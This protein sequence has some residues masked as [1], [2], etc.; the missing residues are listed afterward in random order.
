MSTVERRKQGGYRV[1]AN[2]ERISDWLGTV[3][4]GVGL[5]QLTVLPGRLM[6][7]AEFVGKGLGS[8][9]DATVA[10]PAA[11]VAAGAII[12]YY[13]V[14]GFLLGYL[15]TRL[16]LPLALHEAEAHEA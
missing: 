10:A 16:T 7:L 15:W 5:T 12:V 6:L 1:N 13:G 4:V 11:T 2:L 3:I 8:S 9:P 14:G